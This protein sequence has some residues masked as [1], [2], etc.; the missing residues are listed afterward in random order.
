MKL[1]VTGVAGFIGSKIAEEALRE[2]HQ[3]IGV[4]DLSQGQLE[5]IPAKAQFIQ[6]D[7]SQSNNIDQ[8]PKDIDIILHLAGQSSGEISFDDPILDL[9]KNTVSTLNL[10]RFG[11]ENRV[12]KILYASSMS[13][14]G[15]VDDKP[16]SEHEDCHPLSCYGAGK[17][18]SENYLKIYQHEL[19]FVAFRMFNVY[20]PGQDLSNLRQGMVSI[21]LSYALK[22]HTIPIKGSLTRFRD[23]IYID[24]VVKVWMQAI[25][26]SAVTNRILNLG[27]GEK[28][29]VQN[30]MDQ[31]KEIIPNLSWTENENTPGDQFGVYA[32]ISSLKNL[33]GFSNFTP[34]STGLRSFAEWAQK[35]IQKKVL[36]KG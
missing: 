32:D 17:L 7:L 14:Y 16:I 12:R 31:L 10:I 22:N 13:V 26:S 20:G 29:T 18:A 35:R 30:L 4:D 9:S 33:L 8:I 28:T 11:I 21:Y 6:L 2:G 5:N 25:H 24:D 1:L 19:P 15:H 23:F 27:T 3:V 34:L 36:Q